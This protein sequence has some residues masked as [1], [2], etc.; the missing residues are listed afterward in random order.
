LG[1]TS[2]SPP[3]PPSRNTSSLRSP[4]HFSVLT[5]TPGIDRRVEPLPAF[6]TVGPVSLCGR[7]LLSTYGCAGARRF[8]PSIGLFSFFFDF[9]TPSD[10]TLPNPILFLEVNT[11][12]ELTTLVHLLVMVSQKHMCLADESIEI[13]ESHSF[14]LVCFSSVERKKNLLDMETPFP[15]PWNRCLLVFYCLPLS[16]DDALRIRF[17]RGEF[18]WMSECGA[19]WISH[20]YGDF[21][22]SHDSRP[23]C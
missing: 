4:F 17:C 10:P 13:P 6:S 15:Y 21:F 3:S 16:R 11:G 8:P 12:Y 18:L 9:T 14:P 1:N 22:A 23:S 20:T 19:T 7:V 2:V 5:L